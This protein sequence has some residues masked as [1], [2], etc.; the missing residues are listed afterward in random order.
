MHSLSGAPVC[1]WRDVPP[2]P[3]RAVLR[4]YV[5]PSQPAVLDTAPSVDEA[6]A[7]L[8]SVRDACEGCKVVA[9][10]LSSLAG[11]GASRSLHFRV[12]SALPPTRRWSLPCASAPRATR[13]R[14][15]TRTPT[16]LLYIRSLPSLPLTND[17]AGYHAADALRVPAVAAMLGAQRS[18]LHAPP[19]RND[20]D[21]CLTGPVPHGASSRPAKRICAR[22]PH[23]PEG[24]SCAHAWQRSCG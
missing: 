8:R 12:L 14:S 15:R 6:A 21:A 23:E 10:N 1:S 16:F 7:E 18:L 3:C 22:L 19:P 20:T 17:S 4:A 13:S 11:E 2:V 5:V 9:F 24:H